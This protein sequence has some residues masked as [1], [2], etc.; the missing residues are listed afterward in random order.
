MTPSD[1]PSAAHI[2]PH[3]PFMWQLDRSLPEMF[4]WQIL[5]VAGMDGQTRGVSSMG[6]SCPPEYQRHATQPNS[7][8]M[9]VEPLA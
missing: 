3:P 4:G 5:V 9:L 2:C 6:M 1:H 7:L 8:I